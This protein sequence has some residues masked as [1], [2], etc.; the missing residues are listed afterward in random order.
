MLS[1]SSPSSRES[2]KPQQPDLVLDESK[3]QGE[4]S[5]SEEPDDEDPFRGPDVGESTSREQGS[6]ENESVGVD[7]PDRFSWR[8]PYGSRDLFWWK[9]E[10]S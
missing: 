4:G 5:K 9:G 2:S 6:S 3:T 10:E 1:R 7:D 8:H